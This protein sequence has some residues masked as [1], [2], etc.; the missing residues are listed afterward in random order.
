MQFAM[1]NDE[2]IVTV[3][4]VAVKCECGYRP[5][6]IPVEAGD[7]QFSNAS[8]N[9]V[10]ACQLVRHKNHKRHRA[11][12]HAPAGLNEAFEAGMN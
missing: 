11:G 9:F 12:A 6:S 7:R 3:V 5:F 4:V 1:R 2:Q 8:L 10:I